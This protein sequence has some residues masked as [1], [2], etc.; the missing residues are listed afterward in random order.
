LARITWVCAHLQ[1]Q[2]LSVDA[3]KTYLV[4]TMA[5]NPVLDILLSDVMR[6]EIALPLQ[7]VLKLYTVGQF[8]RAWQNPKNHKSIEQV[9]DTPQQAAH[10]ATVCAAWTGMRVAVG[11]N[12]NAGWWWPEDQAPVAQA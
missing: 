5:T 12:P 9:F 8:L 3:E 7:H 11:N 2:R 10:A 1:N 4:K 6:S